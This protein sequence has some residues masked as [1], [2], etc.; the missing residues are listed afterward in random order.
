MLRILSKANLQAIS[1]SS[2]FKIYRCHEGTESEYKYSPT[3]SLTS[4]LEGGEW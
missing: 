1:C 3:L 2:K 4:V